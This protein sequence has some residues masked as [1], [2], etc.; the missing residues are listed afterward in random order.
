ML[1]RLAACT[2]VI[3]DS[4]IRNH[5]ACVDP[6]N[7]TFYM[8]EVK[9]AAHPELAAVNYEAQEQ[10]FSWVKWLTHTANPMTP[11]AR[12]SKS[13]FSAAM[14]VAARRLQSPARVFGLLVLATGV[15]RAV[16]A[17]GPEVRPTP[18]ALRRSRSRRLPL[19][20]LRRGL[21]MATTFSAAS[22]HLLLYPPV[23]Q[24]YCSPLFAEAGQKHACSC[25]CILHYFA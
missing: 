1:R 17:S 21:L 15:V 10:V 3:P 18:P 24:F 8:P 23:S 13:L 20:H 25:P 16:L 14:H 9:K 22:T 4:H 11:A 2:F 5:T 19:V 12:T 7:A 6:S